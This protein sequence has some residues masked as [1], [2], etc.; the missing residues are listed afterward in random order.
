MI[1]DSAKVAG[2]PLQDSRRDSLISRLEQ[3]QRGLKPYM[4]H[5]FLLSAIEAAYL[6][7]VS[8]GGSVVLEFGWIKP[9]KDPSLKVIRRI[10][11]VNTLCV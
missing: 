7:C 4:G 9:C 2:G 3:T 1:V 10:S 8:A 5:L 11:S 6:L